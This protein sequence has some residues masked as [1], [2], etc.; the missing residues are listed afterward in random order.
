MANQIAHLAP[1]SN[2][3]H[4]LQLPTINTL[5]F[6]QAESQKEV[7]SDVDSLEYF[8]DKSM[9]INQTNM[10]KRNAVYI[11]NSAAARTSINTAEFF[12]IGHNN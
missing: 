3:F 12:S 5:R 1:T 9:H 11:P 6:L 7:L 8:N 10:V 4:Q 2:A